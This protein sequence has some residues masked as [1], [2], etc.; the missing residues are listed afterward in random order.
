MNVHT[1]LNKAH[2]G[3][4]TEMHENVNVNDTVQL[5]TFILGINRTS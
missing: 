2:D 1:A 5:D 3:F 4:S